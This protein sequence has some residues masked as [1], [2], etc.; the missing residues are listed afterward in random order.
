MGMI[1]RNNKNLMKNILAIML[2]TLFV[3]Q[4]AAQEEIIELYNG[5]APGSEDWNWTEQMQNND[6]LNTSLVY[7]VVKP[8]LTVFRA[9]ESTANG[10]AVIICPGGG[11]HF[12][13]I[14]YEGYD[15]AE[16]LSKNGITA[17]VLKYRLVHCLTDD[18][19]REVMEKQEDTEAS[20]REVNAVI[21]LSIAD[22]KTAIRYVRD[23][24]A[25]YGLSADRI[26]LMGFSA[27]GTVTSGVAYTYDE[28][29]RPDFVAPIYPYVGGFDIPEVPADAPPMFIAAATDDVFELQKHCIDLYSAW[30]KAGQSVELHIYAKGDHGFGMNKKNLPV[31]SWTARFTD[32]LDM[33]GYLE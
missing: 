4:V 3:V 1:K 12:L 7:N 11:F 26:G 14:D 18:P 23:H 6:F 20:D 8:T 31:D 17:F 5:I 32:W 9:D 19:L 2:M 25:E 21:P 28:M 24:A 27:G 29:S 33:L 15:V 30:D 16:W 22:G 13:A 10:T